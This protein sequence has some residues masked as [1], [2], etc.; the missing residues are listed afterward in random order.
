MSYQ[1]CVNFADTAA[2]AVQTF[3][4][5]FGGNVNVKVVLEK[6]EEPKEKREKKGKKRPREKIVLLPDEPKDEPEFECKGH[7]WKTPVTPCQAKPEDRLV[8]KE[9]HI[10]STGEDGKT[11]TT[12]YTVCLGCKK[13][14]TN[15]TRKRRNSQNK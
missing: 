5:E 4:D 8:K 1:A 7:V 9:I 2:N 3:L 14:R 6:R 12:K 10:K 15:E 13:A 11:T